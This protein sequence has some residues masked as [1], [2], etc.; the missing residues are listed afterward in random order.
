VSVGK[1]LRLCTLGEPVQPPPTPPNDRPLP[2]KPDHRPHVTTQ[3]LGEWYSA[4]VDTGAAGSFIGD[5]LR[6]KCYRHLRPVTPTI[7]SARMANG[8][9]DTITEAYWISLKIGT[10][11]I[12][13][14]FHHLPHLP[15]D[16]V[17]GIDVLRQYPFSIDL[18]GGSASL[19]SPA[20]VDVV[21]P[22]PTH[23]RS[24]TVR[25]SF[26]LQMRISAFGSSSRKNFRCLTP[27]ED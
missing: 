9:V 3:I 5:S 21:Q 13:G 14:K 22:T 2:E 24:V 11:T 18:K 7:Q 23:H 12:Q 17:L 15:S 19:Q 6:D 4:L 26:S 27:S 16:L 10:R 8:Q 1:R 25:H 20:A